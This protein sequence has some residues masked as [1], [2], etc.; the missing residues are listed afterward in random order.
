MTTRLLSRMMF[1]M[2]MLALALTLASGGFAQ[3]K[4]GTEIARPAPPPKVPIE[5]T[6]PGRRPIREESLPP[7]T[8][9]QVE[10]VRKAAEGLV[11]PP[12]ASA[13]VKVTVSCS[14]PPLS[15]T[16]TVQF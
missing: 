1:A 5:I 9:A 3:D 14:Y 2:A 7:E 15:C 4:Q 12:G 10:R 11:S 16:I 8:Q 6:G 13:R